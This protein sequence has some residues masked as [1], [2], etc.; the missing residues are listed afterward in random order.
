MDMQ[1]DERIAS[2]LGV[3]P[4]EVQR[5]ALHE[6]THLVAAHAIGR[7]IVYARITPVYM[8]P[9]HP[10]NQTKAPLWS[11][12]YTRNEPGLASELNARRDAGLPLSDEHRDWLVGE[13]VISF[14]GAL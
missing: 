14:A 8:P 13:A 9:N 2:L 10:L 7:R 4:K 1:L 11:L 6:A 12:G 5:T 3:T